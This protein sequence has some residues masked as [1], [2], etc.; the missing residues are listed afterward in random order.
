MDLCSL[1]GPT[2]PAL[3]IKMVNNIFANQ[4]K[5][6]DDLD[7]G[8]SGI[9]QVYYLNMNKFIAQ[10]LTSIFGYSG[11]PVTAQPTGS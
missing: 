5:Y 3:V 4:P 11:L 2:N 10:V 9:I 6:N 7:V 8:I 1:Y